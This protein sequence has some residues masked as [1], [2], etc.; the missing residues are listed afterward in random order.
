MQIEKIDHVHI[1]V[2]DLEKAMKFFTKVLGT[3]FTPPWP[4]EEFKLRA[5]MNPWGIELIEPTAP[6]SVIA[7][8]MGERGGEGLFTL[9][10]R[11]EN[12]DEAVAEME[13]HGLKAMRRLEVPGIIKEVDF[14][15]KD[16]FGV[17]IEL[18]EY[19]PLHEAVWAESMKAAEGSQ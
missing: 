15:P 11:V 2:K 9:S 14:D 3:K 1:H 5:S 13:A 7:Q 16:S 10:F 17:T 4:V 18:C 6:E 19:G 12:L 8:D